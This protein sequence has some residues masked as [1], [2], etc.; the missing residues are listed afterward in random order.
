[1]QINLNY[2]NRTVVA[3]L[4]RRRIEVGKKGQNG[5]TRKLW[6]LQC[7]HY[8]DYDDGFLHI[9]THMYIY[10]HVS[11]AIKVHNFKYIQL[12]ECQ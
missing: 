2:R 4:G 12:T 10:I 1:M 9:F 7:V 3:S 5:G 11:T 6:G 8:L